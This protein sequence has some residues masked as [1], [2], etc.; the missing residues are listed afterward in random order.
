VWKNKRLGGEIQK[1]RADLLL[2]ETS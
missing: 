2:I 1:I